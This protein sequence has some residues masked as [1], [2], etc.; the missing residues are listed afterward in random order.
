MVVTGWSGG[1][2]KAGASYGLYI[3]R[4]NRDKHFMRTWQHVMI[5]L[6]DKT[7]V[8]VNMSLSF[9]RKSTELRSAEIGQWMI[10]SRLA[11][12]PKGNPPTFELKPLG[13]AKF[14]LILP[15]ER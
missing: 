1:S 9:W 15:K 4:A 8:E 14:R 3:G 11:P 6:P 7:E 12:W 10:N 13:P 5:R 2:A